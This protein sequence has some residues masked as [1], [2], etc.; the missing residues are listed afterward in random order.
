MSEKIT[1]LHKESIYLQ[2]AKTVLMRLKDDYDMYIIPSIK[3]KRKEE[4]IE[5][6]KTSYDWLKISNKTEQRLLVSAMYNCL[7][8]DRDSLVKFLQGDYNGIQVTEVH[9]NKKGKAN[10]MTIKIL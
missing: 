10:K 9:K 4:Y 2:G 3:C 6:G 7:I 8:N 1:N 5:D